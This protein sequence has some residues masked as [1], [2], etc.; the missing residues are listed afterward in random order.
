MLPFTVDDRNSAYA[1]YKIKTFGA[2]LKDFRFSKYPRVILKA[3]EAIPDPA[4]VGFLVCALE[5]RP[6][7]TGL[8]FCDHRHRFPEGL[9]AHTPPVERWFQYNGY[10]VV[11]T[12]GGGLYVIAHWLY[13]NGAVGPFFSVQ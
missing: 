8:I 1:S 3:K 10:S 13:E 5:R 2:S 7:M 12:R 9:P 6:V 4:V 11:Q